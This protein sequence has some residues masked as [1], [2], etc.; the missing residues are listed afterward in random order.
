MG[1]K[2]PRLRTKALINY[3]EWT[4]IF[5]GMRSIIILIVLIGILWA[6][7]AFAVDGR[8]FGDALH[9]LSY[10]VQKLDYELPWIHKRGL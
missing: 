1:T 10:Q 3:N 9:Q 2:V 6:I 7:D 8:Y 4:D 5:G